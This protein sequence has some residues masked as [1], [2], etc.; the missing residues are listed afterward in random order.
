MKKNAFLII[1][2][3]FVITLSGCTP[4]LKKQAINYAPKAFEAL[5]IEVNDYINVDRVKWISRNATYYNDV[6]ESLI[7]YY[8]NFKFSN[9]STTKYAGVN[10][11][12]THSSSNLN[13][14]VYIRSTSKQLYDQYILDLELTESVANSQFSGIISFTYETGTMNSRQIRNALNAIG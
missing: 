9:S 13:T 8:I 10:I 14:Y 1:I 7:S 12:K 2:S 11:T 3:L 5:I 4:N 6:T